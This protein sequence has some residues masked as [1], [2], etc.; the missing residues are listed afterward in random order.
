MGDQ[1]G[2]QYFRM[3]CTKVMKDLVKIKGSRDGKV[4]S[5]KFE[6]AIAFETI[7]LLFK[8]RNENEAILIANA[9]HILQ[10]KKPT[11]V[12]ENYC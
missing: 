9:P 7:I 12:A 11:V 8:L 5:I 2:E 1:T 10:F 3:G 6:L 4:L